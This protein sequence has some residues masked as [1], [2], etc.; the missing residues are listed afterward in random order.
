[1]RT[2]V[3]MTIVL[4]LALLLALYP[5]SASAGSGMRL[6]IG[7][8]IRLTSRLLV[9]VPL[10]IICDPLPNT[11]YQN[12]AYVYLTQASGQ[13]VNRG[14]GYRSSYPPSLVCDGTTVNRVVA[15]VLPDADSGPFHG[16]SAI[17][18]AS[19]YYQ[20]AQSCGDWCHYDFQ[21]VWDDTGLMTVRL[22]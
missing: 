16:G 9:E 5:A 15:Q 21:S 4:V 12:E 11:P 13:T 3:S 2:K 8:P 20:T 17:L 7:S 18:S 19:A 22:R 14:S 10:E 6:T 1:M